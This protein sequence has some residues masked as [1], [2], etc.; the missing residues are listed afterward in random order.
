[1]SPASPNDLGHA[2][3]TRL[4]LLFS[5][6][7]LSIHLLTNSRYGYFRDE[8]YFIACSRHLDAGY[9][10]MAP[11][12]AWLLRL[13][14]TL[15]GNSLFALRLFP[16]VA[17][18][19][20]VA[21]TG[22]LARE[23]GGRAWAVALACTASLSALLYLAVGNFY[24]MNAFEPL[25]WM[26]CVWLLVRIMNG[27]SPRLWLLFG[28]IAGLGF[29]NKH[30]FAFFGAALVVALLLTPWRRQLAQPW[31]W[32]GGAVAALLALPNL[33]WQIRHDWATLELLRN[34]A[35]SNKNVVLGPLQFIGQ[36]V[37]LMNP[38][39]LPLWLGGLGWLLL[40]RKGRRYRLLGFA[41]VFALAAFI[42]M[43]GKNYYLG[44]V[45]P[46]LFAA[47]GVAAGDLFAERFRWIKPA[48]M[49]AMLA[50]AALL[51]PTILPI[52]PPEK[53]VAYMKAIQFEPPRTET[54]HTAALPQLFADQFGWEEMVTSVARAY[55]QL[56]PE[57]RNRAA[58]FCQNYGQAGAIDFFGPRHGLPPAL[59]GHQNYY[60]WGPRAHT[61]D[62]V[63]V[64]GADADD[65]R[66]QFR[67]VE[68]L[69]PVASSRWA[70]PW[71]QRLRI[72]LCRDLKVPLRE[73]WPAVKKWR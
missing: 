39:T 70:M 24:S 27:G 64:L 54:S 6:A 58:I 49:A 40:A 45:Y 28:A 8:L 9:V 29:E 50:L 5:L 22:T 56:P 59:S 66:E 71:E 52:L 63:L 32:L 34:V 10:D 36:Q 68:D 31:I 51:A 55:H 47:G 13:Q 2:A 38:A 30:S 44:P 12:S 72:Y 57:E 60:L 33:I 61:G 65:E 11:L 7:A 73:A 41:Y 26:G 35:Q 46:M 1:M 37:L 17:G 69:G 67:S 3:I 48:L 53:L 19:L 62:V 21:L 43:K 23:M 18:T 4:L 25:F 15:F 20:T 16:A 42:V 14:G